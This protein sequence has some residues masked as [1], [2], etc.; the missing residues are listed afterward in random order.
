MDLGAD[1]YVSKPFDPYFLEATVGSI[2][3]NRGLLQERILK[4]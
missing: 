3:R 1:A 2:L 4:E